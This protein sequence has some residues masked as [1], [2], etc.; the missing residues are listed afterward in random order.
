MCGPAFFALT[1]AE[2]H[3]NDARQT[4]R[5]RDISTVCSLLKRAKGRPRNRAQ[6]YPRYRM[7]KELLDA[8]AD[9]L[10]DSLDR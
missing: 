6:G 5:R 2:V 7:L 4:L 3:V 9:R 1:P 10:A 8:Y